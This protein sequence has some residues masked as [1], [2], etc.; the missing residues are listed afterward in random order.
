MPAPVL[1]NP[2]AD[3][4]IIAERAWDYQFPE[5][6]FSSAT[7]ITYTATLDDDSPLPLWLTFTGNQRRFTG[8]P[9]SSDDRVIDIKVTADNGLT[10]T[11]TFQL[12][13]CDV[14][15]DDL[16]LE[17]IIPATTKYTRQIK[18]A[19]KKIKE[20]GQVVV[21]RQVTREVDVSQP[22]KPEDQLVAEY[23]VELVVIPDKF[24]KS[25]VTS[26]KKDTLIPEGYSLAFMGQQVFEPRL[27]DIAVINGI[28][29]KV[30]YI[31]TIGPDGQS[32]LHKIGLEK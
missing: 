13:I 32:I 4:E 26:F 22:W 24:E 23:T 14:P 31:D 25:F 16:H 1:D 2:L 20:K 15:D 10:T 30:G 17:E 27:N 12:V 7:P 3:Q 8:T 5:D 9:A 29:R 19:L 11:D 18:S 6:T 21:W 28:E